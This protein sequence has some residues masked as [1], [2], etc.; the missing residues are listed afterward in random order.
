MFYITEQLYITCFFFFYLVF[1]LFNF[2]QNVNDVKYITSCLE[3]APT[4]DVFYVTI[5]RNVYFMANSSSNIVW[6]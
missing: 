3:C 1:A 5:R 2:F 6:S 4:D